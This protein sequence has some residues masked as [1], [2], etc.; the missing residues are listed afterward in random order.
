MA[1]DMNYI[2]FEATCS[3]ASLPTGYIGRVA[4]S[5][6]LTKPRSVI[7]SRDG[8]TGLKCTNY[9][10]SLIRR[11]FTS[12]TSVSTDFGVKLTRHCWLMRLETNPQSHAFFC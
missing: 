3:K 11:Q 1:V 6:K 9:F 2:Q 12:R 4:A 10:A 8:F 5:I 7:D